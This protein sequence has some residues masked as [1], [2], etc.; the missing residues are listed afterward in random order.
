MT[1]T[2]FAAIEAPA[3]TGT[4]PTQSTEPTEFT[5][6]DSENTATP[7]P[8]ATSAPGPSATS[9][10]GFAITSFVLG[11]AS[12]VA[13]WTFVAPIIGFVLGMLAL[14]RGTSERTL[15]LWGVWINGVI[16]A[17]TAVGILVISMAIAAGIFALPFVLA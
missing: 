11:I 7:T 3:N 17:I 8:A 14:R 10:R 13:G 6:P 12:V 2:T 16:L 9:N 15:A 5:V 1:T 4:V